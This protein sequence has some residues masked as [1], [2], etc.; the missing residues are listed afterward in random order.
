MK[1]L[2]KAIKN[3]KAWMMMLVDV[4]FTIIYLAIN[5]KILMWISAAT[6]AANNEE[7][8]HFVNL[9]IVGCAVNTV[10][11]FISSMCKVSKHML[12]TYISNALADKVLDADVAMFDKHSPAAI[13]HASGNIWK[14]SGIPDLALRNIRFIIAIVV[15]LVAIISLVP[16]H[17][18]VLI[19]VVFVIATILT[20]IVN[21]VWNKIDAKTDTIIK[22]RN[23]ELDEITNGFIEAR[24]FA[25]T[26][27]THRSSIYNYNSQIMRTIIKRNGISSS[28]DVVLEVATS[29]AFIIALLYVVATDSISSAAGVALV[30]Y[31]WRLSEPMI[32]LVFGLSDFSDMKS[33]LPKIEEIMEYEN[34]MVN[35]DIKLT[36][37][38]SEIVLRNV[39][40][41]YNT[42]D[43]VLD[44]ISMTIP[45]GSNIGICGPSGGG[46]STLLKL[47]PRFY[48]V[49]E[50]SIEIDGINIKELTKSSMMSHIGVVHQDIY[51]F[52]GTIKDNIC[53]G[54]K[55][56]NVSESEIV[57][58]CKKAN[59]WDFI[60]SLP[61]GL[62]TEVG[63]RGLKLS[64]GQKQRISIARVFLTNPDIILMDEATA[65]LDNES[66]KAVQES[67]KLFKGKTIITVAHRLS[68]IK[69]CDTIYVIDSH[70]IVEAGTHKQLM[71]LKGKYYEL[72]NK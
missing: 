31:I 4:V 16:V 19:L 17:I 24:S 39:S 46:K 1:Y 65:A 14:I 8:M 10:L 29:V 18:L 35:G 25:D 55:P 54:R 27:E 36:S 23:A 66:E 26:V 42:S 47:I 62:Y 60:C 20:I 7:A 22:K 6:S 57:E 12:F 15:N 41:A 34:S 32:S 3:T 61:D 67:L 21:S 68:T 43:L 63:P 52:D 56:H 48:D 5:A 58:A 53:Y 11:G 50:G 44:D 33:A 13:S 40:F 9:I 51:I 37:F 45:K 30:M 2:L 70:R 71:N 28:L 72:A 49:S 38:D 64:G 69:E 59:I